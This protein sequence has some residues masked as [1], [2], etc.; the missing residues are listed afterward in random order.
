M[1]KL[2]SWFSYVKDVSTVQGSFWPPGIYLNKIGSGL[3]DDAIYQISR[4]Y[5]L[6]I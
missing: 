2:F 3:L 6:W 5:A 1:K 4:R